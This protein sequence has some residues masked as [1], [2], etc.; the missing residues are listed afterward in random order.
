M[1]Y[2]TIGEVVTPYRLPSTD[3]P[4][5]RY[6]IPADGSRIGEVDASPP[7]VALPEGGFPTVDH[8]RDGGIRTRD[9]LNP[10]QVR[11]RAAL[12]P[13]RRIAR[14]LVNVVDRQSEGHSERSGDGESFQ[15]PL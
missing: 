6:P 9:P 13:V 3:P 4:Y 11:Y 14:T 15:S 7:I 10:I 8:D 2:I 12:R 5:Q 1:I